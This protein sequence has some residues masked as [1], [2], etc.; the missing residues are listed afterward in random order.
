M[1]HDSGKYTK[2]IEDLRSNLKS[3]EKW[4]LK[5][6]KEFTHFE[7]IANKL[8]HVSNFDEHVVWFKKEIFTDDKK[9]ILFEEKLKP[10]L[11][12]IREELPYL[13]KILP[14][15]HLD[16]INQ[17]LTDSESTLSNFIG[18]N[19]VVGNV[20]TSIFDKKDTA[21]IANLKSDLT[22][23]ANALLDIL[24]D[25]K[26]IEQVFV[27]QE[28][29][30]SDYEQDKVATAVD[31]HFSK[32]ISAIFNDIFYGGKHYINSHDLYHEITRFKHTGDLAGG[33][34]SSHISEHSHPF[35][36][37]NHSDLDLLLKSISDNTIFS[38]NIDLKIKAENFFNKQKGFPF[39]GSDVFTFI[40]SVLE[41]LYCNQDHS[42]H[43]RFLPTHLLSTEILTPEKKEHLLQS[44]FN[45]HLKEVVLHE[46][47]M[48][49]ASWGNVLE[50]NGL[51]FHNS[52][53]MGTLTGLLIP[54]VLHV[55][56]RVGM[57]HL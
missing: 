32:L 3:A 22:K 47:Q 7:Q 38:H 20:I 17:N 25:L 54:V 44:F 31:L 12:K 36:H 42:I 51:V 24:D 43:T 13:E 30:L 10:F 16:S 33:Y 35:I 57:K 37:L 49:H 6:N 48:N 2:V 52:N 46:Y 4:S 50:R 56:G 11:N 39:S 41:M 34:L 29:I 5:E 1:S 45:Y 28:R 40:I 23:C 9:A 21:L 19:G 15:D 53:T 18:P 55:M 8:G 27:I 26:K 14:S